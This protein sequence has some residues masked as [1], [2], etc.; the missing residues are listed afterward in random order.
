MEVTNGKNGIFGLQRK[1]TDIL[2][3]FIFIFLRTKRINVL[4]VDGQSLYFRQE[5]TIMFVIMKYAVNR[6]HWLVGV[7]VYRHVIG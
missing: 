1:Y 4:L 6:T 3:W 7:L 2:F 5:Q